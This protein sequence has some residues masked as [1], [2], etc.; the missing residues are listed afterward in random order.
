[1]DYFYIQAL[2]LNDLSSSSLATHYSEYSEPV[3]TGAVT[4]R[5]IHVQPVIAVSVRTWEN[6][7]ENL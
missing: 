6:D 4:K 5:T 1:M 3:D 7:P 2:L